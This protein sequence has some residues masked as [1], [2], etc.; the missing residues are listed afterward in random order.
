MFERTM[1][2]SWGEMDFNG[3]LA[4]TAYLDKAATCRMMFFAENGFPMSEF[5]RL[6][7]GPVIM[8]DEIDYQR[9]VSLLEPLRVTLSIAGMAEDG[10]RW[11]MDN[12]FFRGD[13][14]LA[15]RVRSVG[16]WLHL[17]ERRLTRPPEALLSALGG[18]PRS[19]GYAV[20][21]SSLKGR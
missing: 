19:E 13:G 10:S 17:G 4:N 15:A 20:L 8:R 14:K 18:L 16:G 5:R 6:Q 12:E 7:L 2:A 9:E 3:H 21:P 11:M 1:P